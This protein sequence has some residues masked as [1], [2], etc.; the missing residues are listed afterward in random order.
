[1]GKFAQADP[2]DRVRVLSVRLSYE[3][4]EQ[5]TERAREIGVGSSTLARTMIRRGLAGPAGAGG[6]GADFVFAG[7]G[8]PAVTVETASHADLESLQTRVTALEEWVQQQNAN[9]A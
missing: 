9:Q 3:E 6:A 7:S 8:V 1:M 2:G 4:F 5:L